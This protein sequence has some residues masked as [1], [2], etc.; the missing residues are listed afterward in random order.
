MC[1]GHV[2]AEHRLQVVDE[3][4]GDVGAGVGDQFIGHQL[5]LTGNFLERTQTVFDG[6]LTGAV[7]GDSTVAIL[8]SGETDGILA[9]CAGFS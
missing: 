9:D 1:L 2:R 4:G 8:V 7:N 6:I 3:N 5:G